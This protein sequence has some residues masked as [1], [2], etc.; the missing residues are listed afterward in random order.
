MEPEIRT[1]TEKK[2]VGKSIIMSLSC[3]KTGELWLSFMPE[4]KEIKNNIGT[5]LYSIEI[6][7]PFYFT[8]FN[9][10]TEFEK[11]AAMEV[12]DFQTIPDEMENITLPEGLYAVFIHKG[13]ASSGPKTYQY[14]FGTWLP[15]S[16]FI[17]ENR[18]HFAVMGQ[19]YKKDDP[20]SEEEVWIPVRP[21]E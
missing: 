5:E 2:L 7:P 20:D 15:A 3:N 4:R 6:Y 1:I 12:T 11:W 19:K 18:P 8:K 10:D 14:I 17:L 21:K 9:P 16:E 13:P